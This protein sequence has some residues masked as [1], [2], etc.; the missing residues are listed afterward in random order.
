[1]TNK[2][3]KE[4]FAKVE[5]EYPIK[6]IS[7]VYEAVLHLRNTAKYMW[8]EEGKTAIMNEFQGDELKYTVQRDFIEKS[9]KTRETE[10]AFLQKALVKE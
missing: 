6:E 1:M 2:Q 9:L 10:L 4:I 7:G 5:T 3:L 8:S